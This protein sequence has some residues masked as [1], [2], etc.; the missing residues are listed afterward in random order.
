MAKNEFKPFATAS[1]A[2]VTAQSD[3]ETLPA[4]SAGFQS[5]KASSAQI[6]KAIRQATV[7]ASV[8]AQFI[9]DESKN[10]VLD[11]GDVAVLQQSLLAALK[12][13]AADNLP[14][15]STTVA[16]IAKLSSDTNSSNEAV[17]AT[18]KAVKAAN[19]NANSR[20]LATA[21]AAAATKLA[22]SRTI[23]GVSFDGTANIN[24]PGVNAAGNQATTGNA[25]T[26]T[27][28]AT[29][30]TIN[31]VAFDGST[32]IRLLRRLTVLRLIPPVQRIS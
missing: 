9:A 26:A 11:D 13:N 7:I 5:G 10:D 6:N 29:A 18:P 20:L 23:G 14:K 30:R 12:Q 17:A 22:T 27:K 25:G 15:A 3:Y 19:D 24:L 1:G 16:G 8:V 32:N 2:N 4:R 31:G 28:L 21:T